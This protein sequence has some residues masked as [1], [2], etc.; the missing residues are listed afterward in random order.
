MFCPSTPT[1]GEVLPFHADHSPGPVDVDLNV[2]VCLD[3]LD[4]RFVGYLTSL[5]A[6]PRRRP[7]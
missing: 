4:N 3:G 1:T 7:R 5:S 6:V 2:A